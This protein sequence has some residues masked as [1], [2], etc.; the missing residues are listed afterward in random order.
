[1]IEFGLHMCE[2]SFD[3]SR[4]ELHWDEHCRRYMLFENN[5]EER[6][7]L[8]VGEWSLGFDDADIA[9]VESAEG[10][11]LW[12]CDLCAYTVVKHP[13]EQTIIV[14]D[15]SRGQQ[16]TLEEF[17]QQHHSFRVP[18]CSPGRSKPDDIDVCVLDNSFAGVYVLWSLNSLY[19]VF[20]NAVQSTCS[21]WYQNWWKW[22]EKTVIRFGIDCYSHLRKPCAYTLS[23]ADDEATNH[24]R[25]LPYATM[26]TF[27]ALVLLAKWGTCATHRPQKNQGFV[28]NWS[29]CFQGLFDTFA[30]CEEPTAI[31]VYLDP[32][33]EMR[34]GLPTKGNNAIELIIDQG[35]IDLTPLTTC[36]EACVVKLLEL[37]ETFPVPNA[38]PLALFCLELSKS[39][40]KG[41]WLWSQIIS[42]VARIIDVVVME[43]L[44]TI[45]ADQT[46]LLHSGDPETL[47]VSRAGAQRQFRARREKLRMQIAPLKLDDRDRRLLHYF[48]CIR[49]LFNDAGTIHVAFDA[50]RIGGLNRMLGFITRPN[51]EGA[52]M[53][54]Q[55]QAFF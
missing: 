6:I 13:T 34:V 11:S 2:V 39:G 46:N 16:F 18:I 55:V 52:W 23:S 42:C 47:L 15:E 50:S 40:R 25:F 30:Y 17:R 48:F 7:M 5:T 10:E 19:A 9:F 54:P 3:A 38:V 4:F 21:K 1:M 45:S 29:D 32:L 20:I 53:P 49:E 41:M 8:D 33:V 31:L 36:D 26:S 27:S 22:W 44:K 12:C 28:R 51:G 37:L 35:H 43:K 14:F 24:C